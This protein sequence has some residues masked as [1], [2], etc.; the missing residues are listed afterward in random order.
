VFCFV[1]SKGD[2]TG[3][4]HNQEWH[5]YANCHNP[6]ICPVPALAC[7]I[8]SN[9]GAFSANVDEIVKKHKE[10][11]VEVEAHGGGWTRPLCS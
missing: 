4:N 11:G 2:Q 8:F 6:E 1:K 9:S 5:V 7:Y 10:N 3:Q